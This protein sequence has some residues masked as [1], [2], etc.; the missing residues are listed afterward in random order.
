[1]FD[2]VVTSPLG[3]LR[4]CI[5]VLR[6]VTVLAT[7]PPSRKRRAGD[8]QKGILDVRGETGQARLFDALTTQGTAC[9]H[10]ERRKLGLGAL[11]HRT[12]C[13]RFE[14]PSGRATVPTCAPYSV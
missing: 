6:D 2:D 11:Q 10:A 8:H 12:R 4:I 14:Q 7:G 13:A 3:V 9:T 5:A 1:M